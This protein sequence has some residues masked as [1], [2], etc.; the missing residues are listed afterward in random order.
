MLDKIRQLSPQG[1]VQV[2]EL[3]DKILTEEER[4]RHNRAFTG[5]L[6]GLSEDSFRRMWDNPKD[7]EYDDL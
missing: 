1:F 6:T 3:V 4:E 2:S 7:A 5:A